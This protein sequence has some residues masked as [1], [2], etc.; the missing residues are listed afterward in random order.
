MHFYG[1][2]LAAG[3]LTADVAWNHE[4]AGN[5]Y[6]AMS[7]VWKRDKAD[8]EITWN[9][10]GTDRGLTP[11]IPRKGSVKPALALELGRNITKFTYDVDGR[12]TANDVRVVGR[13][14][15][16]TKEVGQAGGPYPT[17]LGGHQFEAVESPPQEVDGQGL[18]DLATTEER[19]LRAPL[20]VPT[21]T[22]K[23]EGLLDRSEVGGPLAVGDVLPVRMQ[24][25]LIQEN[26]LRRVVKMTLHT[27]TDEIDLTL[28]AVI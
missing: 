1:S 20:I 8:V 10:T 11:Y 16:D 25:G 3:S 26:D 13:N 18:I 17:A 28:N 15:G 14:S 21:V 12:Q 2:T 6:E 24:H 9:P 19:R 23:A 5:I 27:S 4:D 22:V 7:E